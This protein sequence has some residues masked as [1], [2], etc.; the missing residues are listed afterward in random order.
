MEIATSLVGRSV[1]APRV[2]RIRCLIN[3][4]S[5][6]EGTSV[7]HL[8]LVRVLVDEPHDDSHLL[9]TFCFRNH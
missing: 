7:A 9:F 2:E 3:D 1:E 8:V 4:P 6:R 5:G